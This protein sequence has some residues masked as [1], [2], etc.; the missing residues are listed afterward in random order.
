MKTIHI[1]PSNEAEE[2][3]ITEKCKCK[4]EDLGTKGK[5]LFHKSF[6]GREYFVIKEEGTKFKKIPFLYVGMPVEN[7]DEEKNE[8]KSA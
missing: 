2:H 6:D 1:M 3:E 4:P 7:K 8:D 5:V